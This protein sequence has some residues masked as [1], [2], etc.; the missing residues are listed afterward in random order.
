MV[1]DEERDYMYRVYAHD[2]QMRINLGIRRRLAPLMRGNRR[3]I[4]LMNA[5][6]FS[7]LGTPI[8]Y[9][10]DELGMGDNIYLGDRNGVRTPMQW[11]ADRNAGFSTAHPHR[12]YLPVIIDPEYHYEFVNVESQ[13]NNPSWLL[14]WMK[15]LIA[16]RK[17]HPAFARGSVE[18]LNPENH[19]VLAFIRRHE[20][21]QMLV[22]ANLSRF[23]QVARLDL[24]EF[25]NRVPVELFGRNE[26][27]APTE[28]PYTL[29]LGPHSFYWF[30]LAPAAGRVEVRD[31]EIP[32]VTVRGPWHR[33]LTGTRQPALE[34][35]LLRV[36]KE[37][38]WFGGKDRPASGASLLDVVP[39]D[40]DPGKA[41][42]YFALVTVEYRDG[43]PEVY[44]LPLGY[45]P[46]TEGERPEYALVRVNASDGAG[47]LVDGARHEA[48]HRALLA[49]ISRGRIFKGNRGELAGHG[50]RRFRT[51]LRE[52]ADLATR[53]LRAE[54]SNSSVIYGN[55]FILKIYRRLHDGINPDLEVGTHLTETRG[56]EG[57]P[58]VAGHLQYRP[59]RG[60]A[61][62]AA[63]LQEFVDASSDAWQY[64]LEE[65]DRYYERVLATWGRESA[66]PP[67]PPRWPVEPFEVSE[68][69]REVCGSYLGDAELLGERTARL[70]LALADRQEGGEFAPLPFSEL[71]QRSLHQSIRADVQRTAQALRRAVPR[72]PAES[73]KDIAT[74]I[75]HEATLLQFLRHLLGTRLDG[76]RIRIHGDYHLGQVL[77][78]GAD[79]VVIDFE[80]EPNRPLSERRI[81]RSP[82]RDVAGM[83]RSFHYA[84]NAPLLRPETGNVVRSVDTAGMQDW[85]RYWYEWSRVAFLRGYLQ[86]MAGS[87]LLPSDPRQCEM[88][89]ECFMVQKLMYELN[90]ELGNRPD[91]LAIPL[92]GAIE[93]I[94]ANCAD[95]GG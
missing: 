47:Y 12:L 8:V 53:P 82:L 79:F 36:L 85:A 27:P 83:V 73:Q 50:N 10:G 61:M 55:Q 54:Q 26:F 46:S 1:T 94:Q 37:R 52:A 2:P 60:G 35:V 66:P 92:A 57:T 64:T 67:R 45:V 6:L 39:L 32:D 58:A 49:A 9:Y 43:E 23:P 41:S 86:A 15:R 33:A 63:V 38:R 18:L 59:A 95:T 91:W 34:P 16:L 40:G 75:E 90:Y 21:E 76:Q 87:D 70:H 51:R 48:T 11:S 31:D 74:V 13:Q 42:A 93:L 72:L 56:F 88:L 44:A 71:Y 17:Q 29:S 4:E 78:T 89:L 5:L 24:A 77:Y 65:L 80:G 22:V 3:L 7:L 25:K 84:A 20:S 19:K 14:W 69:A 62:T 81:K 30:E 68:E 28:E